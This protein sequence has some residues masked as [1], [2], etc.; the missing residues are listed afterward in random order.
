MIVVRNVF[1]LEFGKAKDAKV[2][3]NEF[4]NLMKKYGETPPRFMTDLTGTFYTIVMENS[5]GSLSEY[6][7]ESGETMG[8]EEFDQWYRKFVPIVQSG[9]RE[10][11]TVVD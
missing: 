1:Q 11:F 5:Y 7:K 4:R 3:I 9:H 10:I 6:E 8:K 2:L